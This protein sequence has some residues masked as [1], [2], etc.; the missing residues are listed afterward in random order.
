[1]KVSRNLIV[2]L[3]VL[4]LL[5]FTSMTVY[6]G[7]GA[8]KDDTEAQRPNVFRIGIGY[9]DLG[10]MDPHMASSTRD[11]N[12][13]D[14]IFNGLIRYKPGDS[15]VFEPDLAEA[16]PEPEMIGG[17]Q[18]WTFKLKKG[19]MVHASDV[20]P[21]Y[22]LTSEDV[23]YSLK[24]A[25]T[26]ERSAYASEYDGM[27]F[28]AV[29]KYTVTITLENPLSPVLFL[30]KVSD[31]AGGFII[32]KKPIEA[33][34]DDEFKTHAAGTGPFMVTNY[35]SQKGVT[36]VANEDYFRG[37]PLLDGV[38]FR[39]VPEISSREF[40]LAAG[41]LDAIASLGQVARLEQMAMLPDSIID[42]FGVAEVI[43]MHFNT[44]KPPFN[45]LKLRQALAYGTSRDDL[46]AMFSQKVYQKVYSPVPVQYLAGG[47][48][49]N[50]TAAAGIE[51]K[52]DLAKAKK[53]LAEAGY[54]D[55]LSFEV[56]VSESST[57]RT[58]YENLQAQWA[59]VGV[60]L[61]IKMVDHSSMHKL[62][63]DDANPMVVYIAWRPNA[64]VYLT[65]FYHSAS[66]VVTGAKPD[67]NF[68]HYVGI[69]S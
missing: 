42:V 39:Y 63:R 2:I 54:A 14:M 30:P 37:K 11:R 19:V 24:K 13:V 5:V 45:N 46:L 40:A 53:L 1:M 16:V 64:D 3:T 67:T 33:M 44:S 25:A 66:T 35:E 4:M 47:L 7:G 65:R 26:T 69:D 34:G 38:D 31:Y 41:Q 9:A 50:E 17:K 59:K 18:V 49:Q 36:L 15:K 23:V 52:I 27:T 58:T 60:D 68:S 48:T 12:L 28:K 56:N 51:Y 21:S 20:T 10:T 55:G 6:G 8:E 57:Y 61:K 32:P 22:E 62:I 29:D 43:T